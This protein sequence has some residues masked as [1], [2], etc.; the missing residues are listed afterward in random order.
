M[1][2]PAVSSAGGV[3]ETVTRLLQPQTHVIAAQARATAIQNLPSLACY[4]GEDGDAADSFDRWIES[5]PSLL[6]G[7]P[8]SS[9]IS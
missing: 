8:V 6:N 9:F 3:I 7:L 1:E 5:G 4:T 2:I